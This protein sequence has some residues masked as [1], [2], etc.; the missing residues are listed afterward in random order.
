MSRRLILLG[1]V[2]LVRRVRRVLRRPVPGPR[3][4]VVVYCLSCG[5]VQR[6]QRVDCVERVPG[7]PCGG[8]LPCGLQLV[9][10]EWTV[11]CWQLLYCRERH[12]FSVLAM[13]WRS[14][15]PSR[16]CKQRRQWGVPCRQLL[17]DWQWL[18]CAVHG[19][20]RWS[21]LPCWLQLVERQRAVWARQLLDCWQRHHCVV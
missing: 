8:V 9:E 11:C 18:D 17:C 7:V 6:E 13:S 5:D 10:R 1:A 3:W 12:E 21:V 15:L 2:V 14:I 16:L 4:P 20:S 19:V